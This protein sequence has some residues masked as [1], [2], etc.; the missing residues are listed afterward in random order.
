MKIT[1]ENIVSLVT[2]NCELP[3]NTQILCA[4]VEYKGRTL[5]L[6]GAPHNLP[7]NYFKQLL[8]E[9]AKKVKLC[10]K[11]FFESPPLPSSM[12][13]EKFNKAYPPAQIPTKDRAQTAFSNLAVELAFKTQ[14]TVEKAF[15]ELRAISPKKRLEAHNSLLNLNRGN[16]VDFEASITLPNKQAKIDGL[17]PAADADRIF[18]TYYT[19][20]CK[21]SARPIFFLSTSPVSY[22]LSRGRLTEINKIAKHSLALKNPEFVRQNAIFSNRILRE[23]EQ[24]S[25]Q[26][27]I[28]VFLGLS[29]CF[30][31]KGVLQELQNAGAIISLP[32]GENFLRPNEPDNSSLLSRFFKKLSPFK[33][34]TFSFPKLTRD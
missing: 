21:D 32:S 17:M 9:Y 20:L 5:T 25:S 15:E 7:K 29:H 1:D 31:N 16:I 34:K 23:L 11:I 2:H 26:D 12:T 13:P 33:E 24:A 6:F 30:G 4:T 28:A 8:P 10:N 19:T 27:K 14:K 3:E 18:Q 22:Y